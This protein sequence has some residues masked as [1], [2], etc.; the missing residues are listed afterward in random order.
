MG[1]FVFYGAIGLGLLLVIGFAAIQMR[2]DKPA[3]LL[4]DEPQEVRI[5][6]F[7]FWFGENAKALRIEGIAKHAGAVSA[8]LSAI[9]ET[10]S[11]RWL[12]RQRTSPTGSSW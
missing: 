9:I 6:R 7:W 3:V 11:G 1:E 2:R 8:H 12:R 5:A 10:S 4:D